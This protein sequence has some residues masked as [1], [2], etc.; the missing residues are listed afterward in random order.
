MDFVLIP[1]AGGQ[2]Q[3]WH[4]LVPELERLGHR[5]LAV[6][7][8]AADDRCGLAEYA[9]AVVEAIGDRPDVVLVAQSLAGFSAPLVCGRAPVRLMVLANAMIPRPQETAG[10]W[11]ANTGQAEAKRR[12][13]LAEGRD[14][15]APFDLGAVFLHDLPQDAIDALMSGPEPVQSGTP[16]SQ[17]WPLTAWPDVPTR[18]VVG[19]DDRLFPADFQRRVAIERLGLEADELPGGHLVALS[20]PIQLAALLDGYIAHQ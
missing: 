12:K 4:R 19:R 14:P 13:D 5:A 17:P 15:D 20:Q 2:A 6:D 10:E 16:F 8:P 1:G 18:V 9:G 11:W 7:L 3:Y